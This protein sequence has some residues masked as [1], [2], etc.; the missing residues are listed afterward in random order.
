MND[1]LNN[2]PFF[3]IINFDDNYFQQNQSFLNQN[4]TYS[5]NY[6]STFI[7]SIKKYL[8]SE[9]YINLTGKPLLGIFHSFLTSELIR[10]IR[11]EQK[12]NIYIVSI[13]YED[14]KLDYL[15]LTILLLFFLLKI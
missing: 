7:K 9:N 2:F 15:N 12:N 13:S 4:I 10:K 1:N 5:N 6:I 8:S 14:K 11:S 3:I